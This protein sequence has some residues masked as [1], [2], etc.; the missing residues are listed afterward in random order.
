MDDLNIA[1]V[2]R[3]IASTVPEYVD[4][5]NFE[6]IAGGRSNLTFLVHDQN[7]ERFILRRPPTSH[8]LPTAH[9]MTREFRLITALYPTE[10]PVPRPLALCTDSTVADLPFYLMEYVQ[11]NV[12]VDSSLTEHAYDIA[13]RR[14]ISRRF[15]SV[16]AK[17]HNLDIEQIGLGN[18]AKREGYIKRQLDRWYKQYLDSSTLIDHRIGL[19]DEIYAT[20]SARI[21]QQK[22]TSLVHGDYR[23]DNA[24]IDHQGEVKAILDWEISTLGDPLADLGLLM[25][26]WTEPD[27]K[28]PPLPSV[29]TLDGFVDRKYLATTYQKLTDFDLSDLEYY[30]AFGYWKLAC[31]LEGVYSRYLGG[32]Q[33]GDRSD[34]AG[35]AAQVELLAQK[36][37][38]IMPR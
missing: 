29:T 37:H 10:V 14:A 9:D 3:W 24:I 25:V 16:L 7:G 27:D 30:V 2:T 33:A 13:Q 36:S 8:V 20:L 28:D 11:G 19:I 34:V 31:I 5:Y 21:P 12:L 32:A 17:L 22:T 4:P 1:S 26:Y 18:L 6:L 23:L 35:F 38:E 15:I